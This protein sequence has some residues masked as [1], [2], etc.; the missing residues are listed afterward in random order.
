MGVL[1]KERKGLAK[2]HICITHRHRQQCGDGQREEGE[3]GKGCENRDICKSVDNKNTVKK[4]K[5]RESY[6]HTRS[7][8][9]EMKAKE[10][11]NRMSNEMRLWIQFDHVGILHFLS[12]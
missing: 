11:K 4:K 9:R 3:V 10:R 7:V 1:D 5:K 8:L 2:E 6:P 12:P